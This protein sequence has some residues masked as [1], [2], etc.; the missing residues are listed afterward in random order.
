MSLAAIHVGKTEEGNFEF[1][2]FYHVA[3]YLAAGGPRKIEVIGNNKKCELCAE[4]LK[5]FDSIYVTSKSAFSKGSKSP[6]ETANYFKKEALKNIS[7]RVADEMQKVVGAAKKSLKKSEKKILNA[8]L[9][10]F[11][12]LKKT[13]L[14]WVRKGGYKPERN[15]TK[16]SY[17]QLIDLVQTCGYK[18]IVIGP[19]TEFGGKDKKNLIEFYDDPLFKDNPLTQLVIL[20]ELCE[21]ADVRFSIGM[22]SGGMDGLGFLRGLKTIYFARTADNG[23]MRK[24]ALA[25][26]AFT[27]IKVQYNTEFVSHNEDELKKACAAVNG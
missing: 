16:K 25:F 6:G 14:V 17:D 12:G 7:K 19:Q 8:R 15:T 27:W 5:K 24:T 23:R 2:E 13:C 20:N 1:G 3:A 4:F 11:K 10:P 9:A 22:M 18:P 21:R 26:P